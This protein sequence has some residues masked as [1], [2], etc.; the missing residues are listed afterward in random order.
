MMSQV[1]AVQAAE[2]SHDNWNLLV[3][4]FVHPVNDGRATQVD[5]EGI[6]QK[7][8]QLQSYLESLSSVTRD[9]F[10]SWN[11]DTQ[12]AFLINVY[13][14]WTVE[15]ILTKY[16][17]LD[18]IK[19]LG[20]FFSSPWKKKIVR[21]F[22]ETHSLDDIEHDLIRGSGRYNDPRIHFAVNCASIGCPALRA[23]AFRG[24]ILQQQLDNA[25]T[26]FLKDST[27]NRLAG[28]VLEI[29]SIFK[30]YKEDFEKGWLG[31]NS[32]P[33]FLNSHAGDLGMSDKQKER[34]ASGEI[35]IKYLSYDW[36]LNKI[37]E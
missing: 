6:S 3:R 37:N 11:N 4:E 12:L 13:N 36:K 23:E 35:K 28:D 22:G 7:R 18:S 32:L 24:D 5:Y 33:Q 8:D 25:T 14:S 2:F 31:Y 26:L 16:P 29:S 17:D 19:D 9:D 10:D 20:S 1:F 30:W 15:L 21:L 27:R 34:L